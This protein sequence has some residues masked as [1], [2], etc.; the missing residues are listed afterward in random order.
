MRQNSSFEI[1]IWSDKRRSVSS[2]KEMV[3]NNLETSIPPNTDIRRHF[4]QL[5][6]E[7]V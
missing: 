3:V 7:C 5:L 6:S 1:N 4:T 2:S